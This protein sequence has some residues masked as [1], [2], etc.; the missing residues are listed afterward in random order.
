MTIYSFYLSISFQLLT[1][2]SYTCLSLPNSW[3]LTIILVYLFLIPDSFSYTCCLS[4]IDWF[5][6]F[7]IALKL[8]FYIV[9]LFMHPSSKYVSI[10]LFF[11]FLFPCCISFVD[12]F[13]NSIIAGIQINFLYCS[14]VFVLF[15]FL[16][17]KLET[18]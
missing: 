11:E 13:V 16:F 12:W 3:Q 7:T 9:Q 1:T 8:A 15:V 10:S 18:P 17:I 6:N 5:V 4:F 14:I 2:Y